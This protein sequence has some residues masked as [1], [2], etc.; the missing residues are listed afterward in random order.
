MEHTNQKESTGNA[1]TEYTIKFSEKVNC[2]WLW[3]H[4]D[5]MFFEHFQDHG[6]QSGRTE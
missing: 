4:I 3:E 1:A 6:D 5:A 2:E